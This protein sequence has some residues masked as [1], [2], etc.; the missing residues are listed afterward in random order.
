MFIVK[1]GIL[2]EVDVH[3]YGRHLGEAGCQVDVDVPL[4]GR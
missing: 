3:C 2:G 1:P 4:F